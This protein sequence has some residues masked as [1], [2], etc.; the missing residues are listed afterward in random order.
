VNQ[1]SDKRRLGPPK[2]L[3]VAKLIEGK[4]DR[5]ASPKAEQSKQGYRGWH[6]RGYLPHRDEPGLVQFVTFH[7]V[8]SF[9]D[10][11]RAE[12]EH[13]AKLEDDRERLRELE[14]YLDKGRSECFLRVPEVAKLVEEN[15]RQHAGERYELRALVVM[16]NHVHVLFKVGTASMSETIGAW[17]RNTGRQANKLLGRSGAF[18]AEDY[19]DTFMR[20]AEHELKTVKYIENNPAKA[21]MV[22]DPGDYTWSS[23]RL[24]DEYGSLKL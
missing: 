8:D 18:W 6:E 2:N 19:F 23:A 5:S 24:R 14:A 22:L 3:G 21:K 1:H 13:F 10:A 7:L 20:D 9:P 17:K 12:W 4:R 16:P 11:L 15:F